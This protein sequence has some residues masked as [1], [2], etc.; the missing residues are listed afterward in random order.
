MT[1]IGL[2]HFLPLQTSLLGIYARLF[3]LT[4]HVKELHPGVLN[5]ERERDSHKVST[6]DIPLNRKLPHTVPGIESPGS[7]E[8][9]R[10]VYRTPSL[11]GLPSADRLASKE[12][13]RT[14]EELVPEKPPVDKRSAALSS[15]AVRKKKKTKKNAVDEIFSMF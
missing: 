1:I 10:A 11:S 7:P 4:A 3:G 15:P 2:C 13:R 5:L 14:T 12:S 9:V 8:V 6:S